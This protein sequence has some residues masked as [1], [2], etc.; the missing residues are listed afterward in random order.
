MTGV[1]QTEQPPA[2]E[3]KAEEPN[4]YAG[5]CDSVGRGKLHAAE[6]DDSLRVPPQSVSVDELLATWR[7]RHERGTAWLIRGHYQEAA[8]LLD[9]AVGV[10]GE[11]RDLAPRL[12]V[13]L[14]NLAEVLRRQARFSEAENACWRAMAIR[15]SLY[16]PDHP[17][18]AGGLNAL[19]RAE[20]DHGGTSA[21]R[22]HFEGAFDI[23]T[24][25]GERFLI[26]AAGVQRSLAHLHLA[27]IDCDSAEA[28]LARAAELCRRHE[29]RDGEEH[30]EGTL[31][32]KRWLRIDEAKLAMQRGDFDRAQYALEREWNECERL[33]GP[34]QIETLKV[35]SPFV[36]LFRMTDRPDSA[37][38]LAQQALAIAR[39]THGPVHPDVAAAL[40]ALGLVRKQQA[41]F[42]D[43]EACYRE[44]LSI[45]CEVFG[46]Q[47]PNIAVTLTNL[48]T[49]FLAAGRADLSR[50]PLT[51]A[52]TLRK[53]VYGE[54]HLLYAASLVNLAVLERAD[55]Q[56]QTALQHL[57][58]AH[59][60][61]HQIAPPAHPMLGRIEALTAELD[62]SS[63]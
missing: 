47:H 19:A 33:F 56:Y 42:L 34:M 59:T 52:A 7:D 1:S 28:C 8:R 49:L 2:D 30:R 3:P 13:S 16:G 51:Q 40:N 38:R 6:E 39:N 20:A 18:V 53:H 41:R 60:I 50:Q 46:P 25:A 57:K 32:L 29:S 31:G 5:L 12:A 26:H 44:A 36:D 23:F 63:G 17:G 55:E 35:L 11:A 10:A 48:G 61:V 58:D 43:A 15:E 37:S 62:E 14:I 21:A 4:L 54:P 9:G 45:D 22:Q 24:A 27:S